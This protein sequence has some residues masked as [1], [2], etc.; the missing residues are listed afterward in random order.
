MMMTQPPQLPDILTGLR[1]T[2]F[3]H[4]AAQ[5]STRKSGHTTYELVRPT[6]SRDMSWRRNGERRN[7]ES[8]ET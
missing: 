1:E 6:A 4:R 2:G 8:A 3:W 7:T 5:V